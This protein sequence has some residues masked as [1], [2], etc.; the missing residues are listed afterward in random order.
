MS[1]MFPTT[2][3]RVVTGIG[4]GRKEKE[5]IR[6]EVDTIAKEELNILKETTTN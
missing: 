6:L 4:S 5:L 1:H 3:S 2:I